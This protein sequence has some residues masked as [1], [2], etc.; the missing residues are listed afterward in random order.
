MSWTDER[1]EVLKSLWAQGVSASEIAE[2]IGDG[3]T[4]NSV[5]GK[6]HRMKLTGR[7]SPINRK[8]ALKGPT[9]LV[10]TDRMCKW[11]VG[12]PKTPGFYFCGRV[13]DLSMTYCPE[14]K[15]LAYQ[16][17]KKLPTVPKPV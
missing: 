8:N 7:P 14:H 4:R 15:A 9:L 5:I 2:T 6:A 3:V 13:V 16:Q 12:D 1:I 17:P 10:M 11:P